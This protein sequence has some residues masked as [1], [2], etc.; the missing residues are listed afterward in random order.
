[1]NDL[2]ALAA[3]W[4]LT[5]L[6]AGFTP[7][8]DLNMDG[9]ITNADAD[10]LAAFWLSAD[11]ART[12]VYYYHY[13]GTGSVI[14]LS[15]A[16]G[17]T[18]EAVYYDVFGRRRIVDENFQARTDSQVQNPYFFTGRRFDPETGLYYYRARMYSASLGR[19]LQPD[20]IGY[21]EGM[22]IYKYSSNNPVLYVDPY[23]LLGDKYTP[24]YAELLD[25]FVQNVSGLNNS[26]TGEVL[27]AMNDGFSAWIDGAIP[28]A[29]PLENTYNS[30]EMGFSRGCGVVSRNFAI[31]ATG[32]AAWQAAGGGTM[33]FAFGPAGSYPHVAFGAN[34]TWFGATGAF[35]EMAVSGHGAWVATS[36]SFTLTGIPV[37][38]S[39]AVPTYGL[40]MATSS[41]T[42]P[43]CSAA[44]WSAF[45]ASGGA[46]LASGAGSALIFGTGAELYL[47]N[48][49][50]NN[51][52]TES[53]GYG[54]IG[55]K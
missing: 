35:G 55:R 6:D 28:F 10:I 44:A 47:D 15:D 31:A 37:I 23:G 14:A 42:V 13:D 1:M 40:L 22:N 16:A 17:R 53:S 29:D 49:G 2:R 27:N 43:C 48:K 24:W 34:G 36:S 7:E 19:F 33:S 46:L 45:S 41:A 25:S 54:G 39:A 50:R 30:E 18:V 52:F 21:K 11:G 4:L 32:V 26:P 20:P 9:A 12:A 5:D 3:D 38:N 51:S 8:L